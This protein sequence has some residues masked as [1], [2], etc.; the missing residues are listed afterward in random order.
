MNW[1]DRIHSDPA[2]LLGK[3]VIKGT[4]I[5]VELL[6]NWLAN[7]W[8]E[9]EIFESYPHITREDLQAMFAF[10]AEMNQQALGVPADSSVRQSA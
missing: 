2:I 4:R 5:S 10:L 6:L 9:T 1:R 8:T 7:G 3:P